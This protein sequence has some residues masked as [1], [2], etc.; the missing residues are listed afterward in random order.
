M[1]LPD[2]WGMALCA[3]LAALLLL[4]GFAAILT[5]IRAARVHP[6]PFSWLIWSLV[7][8][9]AAARPLARGAARRPPGPS[10]SAAERGAAGEDHARAW[11]R[12]C[13]RWFGYGLP[14][15]GRSGRP[16]RMGLAR[17]R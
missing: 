14:A 12:F 7:A 2:E 5:G 16:R 8:S 4:A 10:G 15:R 3:G 6:N 9:L 11:I 13:G 17:D 1:D